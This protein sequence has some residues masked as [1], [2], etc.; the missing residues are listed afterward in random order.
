M[1][2]G[3]SRAADFSWRQHHQG[4]GLATG[5]ELLTLPGHAWGVA[6]LAL[7]GDGKRLVSV[8]RDGTVKIWDMDAGIEALTAVASAINERSRIRSIGSFGLVLAVTIAAVLISWPANSV[9]TI[10]RLRVGWLDQSCGGVVK[11]TSVRRTCRVLHSAPTE[12]EHADRTDVWML[13]I[14]KV[15]ADSC[16]RSAPI[17]AQDESGPIIRR[18]AV[19]GV[20]RLVR[21]QFYSL[22]PLAF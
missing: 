22:A 15:V 5:Q 14:R 3:C 1:A 18:K 17:A 11:S 8:G 9:R 12:Q 13:I 19:V 20:G 21:L 6:C 2:S 16:A 7:S 4:V 10:R